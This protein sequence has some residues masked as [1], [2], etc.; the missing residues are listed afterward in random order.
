MEKTDYWSKDR[1]LE[2]E[3]EWNDGGLSGNLVLLRAHRDV[4][5]VSG[6]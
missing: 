6:Y 1:V 2:Q 4:L 3:L 5:S